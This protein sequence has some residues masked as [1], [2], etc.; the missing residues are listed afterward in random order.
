MKIILVFLSSLLLVLSQ[1]R[2]D[3]NKSKLSIDGTSTLH[4]WTSIVERFQANTDLE[5][6]ESN[7]SLTRFDL[8]ADVESIKSGNESMDEN[9]YEAMES[10]DFPKITYQLIRI[11]KSE[12]LDGMYKLS[13]TGNLTIHGV[14]KEIKMNVSIH[15]EDDAINLMGA[16]KFKMSSFGV[17]PP[18]MFLG[19]IKTG[20][21]VTIKFNLTIKFNQEEQ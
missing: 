9:T 8:T 5:I 12:M 14:K 19:T 11:D 20:D 17:D 1:N 21:E 13:T 2:I 18:T 6:N 15:K 7:Y 16:K 4:D 3:L 10:E